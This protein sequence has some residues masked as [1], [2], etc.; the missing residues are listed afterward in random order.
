MLLAPLSMISGG[1]AMA[2][3]HATGIM[4]SSGH[5]PSMEGQSK[6]QSE[7]SIDCMIAC[8]AVTAASAEVANQPIFEAAAPVMPRSAGVRGLQ[9]GFDPPP[10]RVS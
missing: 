1:A 4:A 6:D 10:P 7:S 8:A 5:C 9:P 3:P 2:M